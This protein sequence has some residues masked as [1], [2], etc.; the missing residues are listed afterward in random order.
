MAKKDSRFDRVVS[1]AKKVGDWMSSDVKPLKKMDSKAESYMQGKANKAMSEGKETKAKAYAA[2]EGVRK[3][4]TPTTKGEVAGI[5]A[6]VAGKAVSKVAGKIGKKVLSNKANTTYKKPISEKKLREG[7]EA[8][9]KSEDRMKRKYYNIKE[10]GKDKA[11]TISR[12][13]KKEGIGNKLSSKDKIRT[14]LHRQVK[15]ASKLGSAVRD[16][17]VNREMVMTKRAMG[18]K[19]RN[20]TKE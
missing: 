20:Y 4:V 3:A 13:E 1:G 6:G 14:K 11:I 17:K 16:R 7:V 10:G 18:F 15:T 2:A 8:G 9:N 12:I 5:A 19:G